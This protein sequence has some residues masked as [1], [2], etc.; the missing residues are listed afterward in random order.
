MYKLLF[1]IE[2]IKLFSDKKNKKF[3]LDNFSH[4]DALIYLRKNT[5][6]MLKAIIFG[7]LIELFVLFFISFFSTNDNNIIFH[8]ATKFLNILDIIKFSAPT[9]LFFYCIYQ[10]INLKK[11]NNDN[12]LLKVVLVIKKILKIYVNLNFIIFLLIIYLS[13]YVTLTTSS[14]SQ[15]DNYNT[16][17]FYS[18]LII[19]T[20]IIC[21]VFVLLVFIFYKLLYGKPLKQLNKNY[22]NLKKLL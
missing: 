8:S 19:L 9:I 2:M 11:N 1:I 3:N 21:I 10:Y 7:S 17:A 4:T 15:I 13:I 20:T 5:L 16:I 22:S 18:I 6:S 12:Y 14:T